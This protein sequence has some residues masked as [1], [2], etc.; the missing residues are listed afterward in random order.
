VKSEKRI[1]DICKFIE[2]YQFEFHRVKIGARAAT[3]RNFSRTLTE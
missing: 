3:A 1:Q 2:E